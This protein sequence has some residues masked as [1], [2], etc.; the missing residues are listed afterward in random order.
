MP[1]KNLSNEALGYEGLNFENILQEYLACEFFIVIEEKVSVITPEAERL[2]HLANQQ[3]HSVESLPVPLQ[4]I[5]RE[6]QSGSKITNRPV[7]FSVK[8]SLEISLSITAMP[9]ADEKKNV[10]VL[11]RNIS[12]TGKLE[13]KLQRLDRLASIGTLS[14]SMAHEIRNALVPLKTFV[15]LLLEENR[16]SELAETVRRETQRVDSIVSHM[17]KF[18]T[19]SRP[20]FASVRLHEILEHS[21]RLARHRVGSKVIA[22]NNEF[23]A[24]PDSFK[25]DDHQLEQAFVNLLLNAIEAMGAE[26][27]LTI[28]TE[29]VFDEND[30]LQLRE[31]ESSTKAFRIQISDT[32]MGI[33]AENMEQIFN[34]FF[35]TKQNGTGL[36]LSVTRRIINE[37]KGSIRV[38]SQTGKGTNFTIHLP[39]GEV[40]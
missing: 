15:D 5:I 16:D 32:G 4:T 12:A 1:T 37:H 22:F 23:L 19:P 39:L 40:R 21:L 6:A 20:A 13:R 8:T 18:A 26:G 2:L 17:L 27:T 3:T 25:G 38:E 35:T 10:I 33:S 28:R 9:L 24:L 30:P 36:G 34:P 29:I 31:G 7:T 11:V 14:A